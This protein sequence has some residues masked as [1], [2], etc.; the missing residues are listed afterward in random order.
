MSAPSEILAV[1][2]HADDDDVCAYTG[3]PLAGKVTTSLAL[4][5]GSSNATTVVVL[6]SSLSNATLKAGLVEED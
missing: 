3:Q 2:P 6:L 5:V 1:F 4:K